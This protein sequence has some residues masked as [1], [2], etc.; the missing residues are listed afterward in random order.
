MQ[1]LVSASIDQVDRIVRCV[2]DVE[3]SRLVMDG[4]VVEAAFLLVCW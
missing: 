4:G 1:V 3:R 2:G